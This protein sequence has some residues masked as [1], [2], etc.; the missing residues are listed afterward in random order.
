MS[1]CSSFASCLL[2][3][4]RTGGRT[5]GGSDALYRPTPARSDEQSKGEVSFLYISLL[6][7]L[8]SPSLGRAP[9]AGPESQAPRT[10]LESLDSS[11]PGKVASDNRFLAFESKEGHRRG[12]VPEWCPSGRV[13]TVLTRVSSFPIARLSLSFFATSFVS[14]SFFFAPGRT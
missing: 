11:A 10:H 8:L 2:S 1:V 13:A 9:V 12:H 14:L 5:S 3:R 4:R 6:S 7:S